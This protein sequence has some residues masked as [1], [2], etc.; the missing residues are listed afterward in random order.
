MD[1][2][3]QKYF[4][5]PREGEHYDLGF[6]GCRTLVVGAHH[7]CDLKQCPCYTKCVEEKL[8]ADFDKLCPHNQSLLKT[9]GADSDDYY[10]LSNSNAIELDGYISGCAY[11][12]YSAFTKYMLCKSDYLEES[13]KA[14]FWDRVAFY[15]YTQHF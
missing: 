2:S 7:Y 10:D 15:N 9:L 13:E 5:S 3:A 6:C 11:P 12:A 14:Y 1:S 8:C 4:F